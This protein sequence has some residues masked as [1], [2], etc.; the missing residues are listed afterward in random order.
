[1]ASKCQHLGCSCAEF[2]VPTSKWTKNKSICKACNH[3]KKLHTNEA[4]IVTESY[5]PKEK[6]ITINLSDTIDRI[7]I[8]GVTSKKLIPSASPDKLF[9][10]QEIEQIDDI[11][12]FIV[13]G[14]CR[15]TNESVYE[16]SE[17]IL[18]IILSYYYI[19][20]T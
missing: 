18:Y 7:E 8:E 1:M 3:S 11:S 6:V 4:L 9:Y 10:T 5:H 12:K 20:E 19:F 17:I 13:Y 2:I 15:L 14:Y 16:I